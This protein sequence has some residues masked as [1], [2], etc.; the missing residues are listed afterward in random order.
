MESIGLHDSD[1]AYV[2]IW[3]VKLNK[4]FLRYDLDAQKIISRVNAVV[5]LPKDSEVS[6]IYQERLKKMSP[7]GGVVLPT[8]T[9]ATLTEAVSHLGLDA[10]WVKRS[11]RYAAGSIIREAN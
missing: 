8:K 5:V 10:E 3:R 11:H 6:A 1:R 9:F 4:I 7:A 2:A